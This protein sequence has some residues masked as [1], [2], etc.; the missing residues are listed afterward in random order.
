MK[1]KAKSGGKLKILLTVPIG[2]NVTGLEHLRTQ[3]G[4]E[5]KYL[6]Y[7]YLEFKWYLK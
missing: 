3:S 4:V 2:Y 5:L 1:N 7:K 6:E